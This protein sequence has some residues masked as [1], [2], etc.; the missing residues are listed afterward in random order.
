MTRCDHCRFFHS[1]PPAGSTD[2]IVFAHDGVYGGGQCRRHPPRRY[3]EY[4]LAR[5]P[6]VACDGWCGEFLPAGGDVPHVTPDV[7]PCRRGSALGEPSSARREDATRG[8]TVA[9]GAK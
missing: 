2:E 7:G 8:H 3:E 9:H 6:I 4:R 5:F 1:H